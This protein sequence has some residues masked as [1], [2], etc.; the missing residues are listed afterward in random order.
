MHNSLLP[1]SPLL[2]AGSA[3]RLHAA[4][5]LVIDL[6]GNPGA[7]K[8][9]LIDCT[10]KTLAGRLRSRALTPADRLPTDLRSCDVLLV[11]HPVTLDADAPPAWLPAAALRVVVVSLADGDDLPLRLPALFAECDVVLLNK[12][13]LRPKIA[14]N[15]GRFYDGVRAC[16][17]TAQ[18]FE[19]DCLSGRGIGDWVDFLLALHAG[20]AL[21][22]NAFLEPA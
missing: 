5:V 19:T 4:G 11:E 21:R 14:F 22:R 7:G 15:L 16:N 1:A 3:E 13:D 18:L 6:L 2:T 8:T 17:P 10:Q 9:T 12:I 20:R